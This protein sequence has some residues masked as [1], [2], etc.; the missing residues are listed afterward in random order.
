[1]I[2]PYSNSKIYMIYHC[3]CLDGTFT[4]MNL[5][6]ILRTKVSLDHWT[7]NH[8]YKHIETYLLNVYD[9]PVL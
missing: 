3:P 7:F 2:S 1:M 4:L 5:M 9:K 8:L 6:M